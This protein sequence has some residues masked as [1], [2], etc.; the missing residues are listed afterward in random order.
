MKHLDGWDGEA[1]RVLREGTGTSAAELAQELGVTEARVRRWETGEE[2]P[3][4]HARELL[5]AWL[6]RNPP[7]K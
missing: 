5:D 1:F 3:H 2:Q 7:G 6:A 4:G